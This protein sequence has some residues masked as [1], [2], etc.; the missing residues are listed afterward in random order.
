MK[1][2]LILFLFSLCI[3]ATQAE[4]S[5]ELKFLQHK[6]N[7]AYGQMMNAKKEAELAQQDVTYSEQELT[8]ARNRLAEQERNLETSRKKSI[9]AAQKLERATTRWKEASDILEREWQQSGRY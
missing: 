8:A 5:D 7:E 3:P 2:F 6:A 9:Q 4:L 1:I